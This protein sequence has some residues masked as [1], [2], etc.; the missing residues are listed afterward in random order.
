MFLFGAVRVLHFPKHVAGQFGASSTAFEP[1]FV[2][3]TVE[4]GTGL[5]GHHFLSPKRLSAYGNA[6]I[7]F[8]PI[9]GAF[10]A[11]QSTS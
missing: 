1:F 5:I 9:K 10:V 8:L 2:H 6:A 7:A 11:D 3:R 4:Q